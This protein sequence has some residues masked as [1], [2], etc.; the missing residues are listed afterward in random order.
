MTQNKLFMYHF[1]KEKNISS[2]NNWP[3]MKNQS[4]GAYDKDT[5]LPD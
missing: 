4:L 3:A 5:K 2:E 1:F